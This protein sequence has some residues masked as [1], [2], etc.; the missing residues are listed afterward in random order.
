MLTVG[1]KGA[2]SSGLGGGGGGA[3]DDAMLL[4]MIC[5]SDNRVEGR[6][7]AD[8]RMGEAAGKACGWKRV[9][10]TSA[11][12]STGTAFLVSSTFFGLDSEKRCCCT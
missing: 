1:G 7:F 12:D 4:V 11:A 2:R 6:W 9:R 8:E 10:R 3:D 5:V